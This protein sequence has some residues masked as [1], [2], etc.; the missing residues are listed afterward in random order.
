[1]LTLD[2]TA[3]AR[4]QAATAGIQMLVDLDFDSGILY[5]TTHAVSISWN[6]QTYLGLGD[7]VGV[8]DITESADQGAD[9]LELSFS[10][11]NASILAAMIGPATEYRNR[12]CNVWAQFIDDTFIAAGDAKLRF[13]G[14]MDSPRVERD[15]PNVDGGFVGGKIILPVWRAGQSRMRN[16]SGLRRTHAQQMQKTANADTGLRYTQQLLEQPQLWLSKQFQ[17]V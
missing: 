11:V 12:R 3:S 16:A 2:A 13:S 5:Y 7:L 10:I 6:G 1:M 9:K 15:Q 14:Y 17:R 8:G 4:S